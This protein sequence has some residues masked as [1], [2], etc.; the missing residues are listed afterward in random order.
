[1]NNNNIWGPPAWTFLHT[2][3]YNYPENPTE[4]D[5]RNFYNF[6]MNLQHVLPCEKCK[7]HYKQNI[8]KYDLKN[9]LGSRQELVKW[10]IDLHNDIN[11]DNGKQ[12]WS[13]SDVFNKYQRMY[14]SDSLINKMI[15]FMII[16]IVLILIFFLYNIYDG[17]KVSRKQSF[18]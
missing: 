6:F 10:L 2:V 12:V 17:K 13:Y 1:M 3:T 4:D 16:C 8:Q 7:A 9:N 5:K 18:F 11:K 15:I 14:Q